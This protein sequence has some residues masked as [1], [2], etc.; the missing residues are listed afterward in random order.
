MGTKLVSILMLLSLPALTEAQPAAAPKPDPAAVHRAGETQVNPKDGLTY[1]WIPAGKFLMGCSPGDTDC[2]PHESPAHE[3]AVTKGFWLGRTPV[4]QQAW[5]RVTGHN[6][7]HFK[8]PNLPVEMVDWAEAK[9]YCAAVGG[10]LPTEAEWEYAARAGS[11]GP[12]YGNPN[13]IAWHYDNSGF[14][15][16]DVGQKRP[17]AFGLY[18][19]LGDVFQWV[20]DWYGTYPSG[21]Q[22]DPSG[23]A[24]GQLR[25]VRGGSWDNLSS[26]G[27]ASYRGA[28]APADRNYNFGLRCVEE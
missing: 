20:A 17:N 7:S 4:T 6:R 21:E 12:R 10:R 3:V 26:I 22:I 16:H 28:G 9:A 15:T 27:R 14:K 1:V 13:E 18:D 11:M 23:P 5:L 24:G 2:A 25:V 19:M 8:G